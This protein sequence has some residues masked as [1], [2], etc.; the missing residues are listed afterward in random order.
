M[1]E[2]TLLIELL[3]E[4]LPP[5]SLRQLGE[6]FGEEVTSEL[7]KHRLR[8]RDPRK[9]VFATPRRLAM[10]IE[11][12]RS[13]GL[14]SESWWTGRSARMPKRWKDSRES[15]ASPWAHCSVAR[16]RRAK[17]SSRT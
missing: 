6:A 7:I 5:K 3:T 2:T 10:V 1:S 15:M 12:V 8:N 13:A 14:D 9:H 17:S 11:K 16:P 4:E